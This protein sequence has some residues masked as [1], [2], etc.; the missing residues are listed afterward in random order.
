MSHGSIKSKLPSNYRS[1]TQGPNSCKLYITRYLKSSLSRYRWHYLQRLHIF[2]ILICGNP[3]QAFLNGTFCIFK[4][5]SSNG[6][7]CPLLGGT[8]SAANTHGLAYLSLQLLCYK[9]Y[10]R[11]EISS[12]FIQQD[13]SWARIFQ[14]SCC[15]HTQKDSKPW[16]FHTSKVGALD[17]HHKWNPLLAR[18]H[19]LGIEQ[20]ILRQIGSPLAL[21]L[22]LSSITNWTCTSHKDIWN[23]QISP[24]N[25]CKM[26]CDN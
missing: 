25:F 7:A 19:N 8:V 2:I 18:R 14:T 26:P 5:K 17:I 21:Q 23:P 1:W 11:Q 22:R 16:S 6:W 9:S 13:A 10:R 15:Y 24:N 12:S 4:Y 3:I 20:K